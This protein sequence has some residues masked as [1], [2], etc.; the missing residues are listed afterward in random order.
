MEL[1]VVL[2]ENQAVVEDIATARRAMQQLGINEDDLVDTAY[3]DLLKGD[4]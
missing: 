1:E 3:A 4:A 2:L